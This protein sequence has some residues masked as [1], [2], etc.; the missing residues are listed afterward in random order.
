MK[1]FYEIIKTICLLSFLFICFQELQWFRKCRILWGRKLIQMGLISSCSALHFLHVLTLSHI[2]HFGTLP[3]SLASLWLCEVC[4]G[5]YHKTFGIPVTGKLSG[6]CGS[7]TSRDCGYHLHLVCE[8]PVSNWWR[9]ANYFCI[10]VT[11]NTS[12]WSKY[13]SAVQALSWLAHVPQTFGKSSIFTFFWS[14][15]VVR[16][17]SK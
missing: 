17:I 13:E 6:K 2:T 12:A 15:L 8:V 3:H 14:N 11:V 1:E 5:W 16:Q 4:D 7:W 9:T 10:S